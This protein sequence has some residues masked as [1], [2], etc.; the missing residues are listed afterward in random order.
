[1]GTDMSNFNFT[2][3]QIQ[4][5]VILQREFKKQLR[6]KNKFQY[7][8]DSL[9]NISSQIISRINTSYTH[10]IINSTEYK[11]N[12]DS[13]SQCIEKLKTIPINITLKVM[14]SLSKYKIMITIAEV[15]LKLIN[16]V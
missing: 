11:Q 13:L 10:S 16:I 5:I 14:G 15:K 9:F 2:G 8:L 3:P 6:I 1:M 12:I 4:K 7:E